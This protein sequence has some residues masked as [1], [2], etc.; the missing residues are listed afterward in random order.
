MENKQGKQKFIDRAE[1]ARQSLF[2]ILL[3]YDDITDRDNEDTS[4]NYPFT[5]S[6]DEWIFEYDLWV[7]TLKEKFFPESKTYS[8]T[9]TVKDLKAILSGMDDD[10]QIVIRD[11][12]ADWWLNIESLELP[13]EDNGNL[14]LTFNPKDNFDNRQF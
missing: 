5:G 6:F 8:P 2:K 4:E 13:D 10:I 3:A 9:I 1:E 11:E 12:K 14:A 7:E